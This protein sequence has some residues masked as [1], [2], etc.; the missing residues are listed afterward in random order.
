MNEETKGNIK[1]E[2]VGHIGAV[3]ADDK[4]KNGDKSGKVAKVGKGKTPVKAKPIKGKSAKSA[5]SVKTAKPVKSAKTVKTATK[6]TKAGKSNGKVYPRHGKNP[7]R[8][9]SSYGKVFDVF[10]SFKNGVRRDELLTKVAEAVGKDLKRSGYD[11]AVILSA[12]D[13][14]T[15]SRHRSC[16]EGFWVKRENSN[17]TLMID[18]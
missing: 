11:L 13:S 12:H 6:P 14:N 16:A 2:G 1:D 17:V 10:A 5:K 4:G 15:G 7:F 18:G 8:V 9:N 3:D